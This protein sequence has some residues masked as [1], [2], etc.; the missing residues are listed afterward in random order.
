MAAFGPPMLTQEQAVEIRVLARRGMGMREIA[1]QTGLSRNTVRRYLRDERRLIDTGRAR[2]GRRS[3]IAFRPYIG[4][5][6]EAARPR[7]IP[8]TVLLRELRERGYEGGDQPAEGVH[9]AAEAKRARAGDPI[10]D[11]AGRADAGGLHRGTPRPRSAARVRGHARLQPRD[12]RAVHRWRGRGDA[13]RLPAR[14]FEF[15]GGV[16][17]HV[18]VRQRQDGRHRA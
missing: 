9:S 1:R 6:I 13:V 14:A 7:W 2:R 12:V 10:R 5:R 17:Q 4:E 3:S 8:A 16:P 11:G 18:L 15:F